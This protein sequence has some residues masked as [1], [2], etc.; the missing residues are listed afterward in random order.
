MLVHGAMSYERVV[1]AG[2]HAVEMAIRLVVLT[3][4]A[5]AVDA[6]IEE[7]E[8]VHD[9]D[10]VVKFV[11][12]E[13]EHV[14]GVADVVATRAHAVEMLAQMVCAVVVRARIAFLKQ[15]E[16]VD[17]AVQAVQERVAREVEILA[18]D[19]R[20]GYVHFGHFGDVVFRVFGRPAAS[21]ANEAIAG[22]LYVCREE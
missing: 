4:R 14:D 21:S 3:I 8:A 16:A 22:H 15:L 10:V 19:F 5:A 9:G 18:I 13:A 2:P 7:L 6:A 1:A 12:V 11:G 20:V 17:D